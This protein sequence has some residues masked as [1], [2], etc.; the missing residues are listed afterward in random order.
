[1]QMSA[2]AP[3]GRKRAFGF[4]ELELQ[5]VVSCWTWVLGFKLGFFASTVHILNC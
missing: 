4:L 5:A 2:V 1:M 3:G